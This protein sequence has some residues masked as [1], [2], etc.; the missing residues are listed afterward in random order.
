MKGGYLN[1]QPTLPEEGP[2]SIVPVCD[3][4][5]G[6]LDTK[7]LRSVPANQP[8]VTRVYRVV[9]DTDGVHKGMTIIDPSGDDLEAFRQSCYRRFGEKRV[10]SV[11]PQQRR[12][13]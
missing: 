13:K 9:V 8:P 2:A 6:V 10:I 3:S 5:P 1:A 4:A 12:Q 11:E 7:H